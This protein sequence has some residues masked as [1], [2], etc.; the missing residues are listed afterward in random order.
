MA[1]PKLDNTDIEKNQKIIIQKMD[2][3]SAVLTEKLVPTIQKL[4]TESTVDKMFP[5]VVQ[6]ADNIYNIADKLEAQVTSLKEVK[7]AI[8][9]S[10][11]KA[12]DEGA[13]IEAEREKQKEKKEPERKEKKQKS[14]LE[15]LGEIFE[16]VLIPLIFGFVI[17]L[18]KALGGFEST[19]GRIITIFAALYLALSGFRK[20]VNELVVSGF[21]KLFGGGKPPVPAGGAPAAVPGVPGKAPTPGAPPGAPGAPGAPDL[22]GGKP[23]PSGLDKF[24][25]GAKKVGKS[26]KD[27]FVGIADTIKQVLGKLSEGIKQFITKVSEGI[28]ALLQ[29]IAKGIES[30][31]KTSVLK[32]AAAL[33][34]V[35]GAL[36]VAAKAFKQFADVTWDGVAKGVVAI[37]ALVGVTK[38]LEKS[39]MSMIK[40]AFALG[41]LGG[42]LFVAAKGFEVFTK[43]SWED[44]AKAG[45][46]IVGLTAAVIGLGLAAP[47]VTA[48]TVALGIMSVGLVAFAGAVALLGAGLSTLTTF[49]QQVAALDGGQLAAAAAGITAIGISLAALGAGQVIGALGNFASSILSFGKDDIFTKLTKLGEV[50]GDLNQLPGTIEAL[51]KLS[52]F[53]VSNDFMKNVDMLSAGLKKIAESAKGFEKTGDSLTAL[54]KIAEVMNKPAAGDTPGGAQPGAAPGKPAAGQPQAAPGRQV[55]PEV[56]KDARAL[57]ERA[58]KQEQLAANMRKS[59]NESSAK[60]IENKAAGD[61]RL[62]AQLRNPVDSKGRPLTEE[63]QRAIIEGRPAKVG[64]QLTTDS[65]KVEA[66]KGGA[67]GGSTNVVNAP[68]Q[69]VV[70]APQSQTVNTPLSAFG[71]F[72]GRVSRAVSA[73]F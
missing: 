63:Q 11:P 68:Q 24:L 19:V 33:L 34:V 49:F 51:G 28:K 36:F 57:E 58:A 59:G 35:S 10:K 41:V 14:F 30:F 17:G 15:R 38:L 60:I 27:L 20:K 9:L 65:Q 22:K 5:F 71:T 55:N 18:S 37:T 42:A 32:G 43:I 16:K 40:G 54:A 70:N 62:A 4:S 23:G 45:V 72:G 61:R 12:P 64:E 25:E 8:E 73:L 46:A 2:G 69:S 52:N 39:S 13:S 29:N 7:D 66:A 47:L 3:L 56:E 44:L 21:K 48:G 50:A 67:G 6:I 31:G 1:L 26:I 53:K